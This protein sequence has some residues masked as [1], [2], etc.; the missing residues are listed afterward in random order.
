MTKTI[1]I[2]GAT[3]GIGFET[4]KILRAKG[5]NLLL[6]GRS[7]S[8]LSQ[9]AEAISAI[10][11]EGSVST[12]LAD[13]SDLAETQR[14]AAELAATQASLDVVINNAGVFRMSDARTAEG[15]DARFSVNTIAPYILAL[16][17]APLLGA[18]GRIVNLSSAAQAPV[19]AGSIEGE[20]ALQDNEAYA[21]SKLALTMWTRHLA[22]AW[23]SNG[24]A[25]FAVNPGSLLASKMVKEAYGMSGNDISIGS[26]IL[27][28]AALDEEFNHEKSGR[29]F[30]ND[31]RG[32]GQP[33]AD[34]LDPNKNAAIV[35]RMDGVLTRLGLV[36]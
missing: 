30:D 24:P 18:S 13:L 20:R 31:R 32:W 29:Y 19:V 7:Q 1:L 5:H 4:A 16:K 10:A 12:H 34:A 8:K 25:L 27:V 33:Q 2:T 28:R 14:F 35:Q 11:G 6:H 23:G 15:L 21:Q 9:T 36:D 26:G 3:D 22:D 17:L